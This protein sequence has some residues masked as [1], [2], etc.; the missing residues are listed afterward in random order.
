MKQ[1]DLHRWRGIFGMIGIFGTFGITATTVKLLRSSPPGMF[2][3][4]LTARLSIAEKP[5]LEP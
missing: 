4:H 1:K 2:G 5:R 3:A